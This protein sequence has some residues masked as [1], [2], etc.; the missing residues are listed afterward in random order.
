MG[1]G[2]EARASHSPTTPPPPRGFSPCPFAFRLGAGP[3]RLCGRLAFSRCRGLGPQKGAA[4]RKPS[5]PQKIRRRPG[6]QTPTLCPARLRAKENEAGTPFATQPAGPRWLGPHRPRQLRKGEA[7]PPRPR[8]LSLS[9]PG[10]IF[11]R[12]VR[13]SAR[14]RGRP[15][16]PAAAPETNSARKSAGPRLKAEEGGTR[17]TTTRGGGHNPVFGD[18]PGVGW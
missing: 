18:G 16:R 6:G 7:P 10:G 11:P 12:R 3:A 13:V 17:A 8:H 1:G 4:G 2:G 15:P 14:G 9:R 5:H